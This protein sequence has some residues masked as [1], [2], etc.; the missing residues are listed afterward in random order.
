VPAA[1][2]AALAAVAGLQRG[3]CEV[4]E[5]EPVKPVHESI[6]EATLPY[7]SRHV[8]GLVEFQ[9]LTGCRP[10]E[11]CMVRRCDIDTG[12]AVWLFRPAHHKTAW[13]GK[14][15]VIAIGPKAQA[16]LREFFAPRLED[17]LF[18]PRRAMAE[19]RAEQRA[20]RK[21]RVQPSQQKRGK[22][23]PEKAPGERYTSRSY[24]SAVA[25]ACRKANVQQWC[26]LQLPHSFATQAR[27]QHGLE[28]AQ[29]LLGHVR[30][31]V[32]QVYAE[33]DL[34]LATGIASLIG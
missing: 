26:P 30:A 25:K 7:L 11:A 5:A 24:T 33:R 18:S 6:V 14:S 32:T 10:G 12:G 3:R 8:R 34:T 21:T 29:V 17:Y 4:R 9:R 13:R 23:H 27:K 28:A 15:R 22:A 19:L 31:D 16:L 1:V 2:H 20:K